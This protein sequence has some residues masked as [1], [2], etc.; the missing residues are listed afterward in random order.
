M[1]SLLAPP[2]LQ[3][4]VGQQLSSPTWTDVIRMGLNRSKAVKLVAVYVALG[5]VIMEILF[6]SAWCRPFHNYWS[7][8]AANGTVVLPS[9]LRLR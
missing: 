3:P 9:F 8:P 1:Q 7:V 5:Y 2:L 4:Y 6:F